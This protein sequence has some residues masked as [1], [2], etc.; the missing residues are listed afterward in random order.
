MRNW[1]RVVSSAI[2]SLLFAYYVVASLPLWSSSVLPVLVTLSTIHI[3]SLV[4]TIGL[5]LFYITGCVVNVFVFALSI[6]KRDIYDGGVL[7]GSFHLVNFFMTL[8]VLWM[9]IIWVGLWLSF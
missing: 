8:L 2:Y 3:P 9:A 7:I 1:F 6:S 5:L 4:I